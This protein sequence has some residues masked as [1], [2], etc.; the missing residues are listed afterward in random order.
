MIWELTEGWPYVFSVA[1][2]LF[3]V[4]VSAHAVL[5]KREVRSAVTWLGAIW[6]L[7]VVGAAM[8]LAFGINRIPRRVAR[9][10]SQQKRRRVLAAGLEAAMA[11]PFEESAHPSPELSSLSQLAR[12]APTFPAVGGNAVEL[13]D[14]GD[15]CYRAMI[16]AIEGAERSVALSTY[17][18]DNDRAGAMVA[19]ALVA[20]VDRGVEVRVLIDGIGAHY[21]RPTMLRGLRQRRVPVAAF[22]PSVPWRMRYMNLRNHR[23]ILVVDGTIGFTGGMNIRAG[24]L[25]DAPPAQRI[26]DTHF[27]IR[28]PL[29]GQLMQVFSEDWFFATREEL[30][31]PTWFPSPERAGDVVAMTVPD[32]PDEDFERLTWKIMAAVGWA[33]KRVRIVS[34]YFLPEQKVLAQ[35][36]IAAMRGVEVEIVIPARGNLRLVQWAATAQLGQLLEVGCRVFLSPPPFDHSKFAVIDGLY[37]TFGSANWDARSLRLNFEV[38]VE[39]YDPGVAAQLDAHFEAKAAQGREIDLDDVEGRSML[40]KLRDASARLLLPYL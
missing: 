38:N 6:I 22:L 16:E 33:R 26:Q 29:V 4:A 36:Q 2:A 8:Y 5:S 20:A 21:T 1:S 17:I 13:L 40:R 18:F 23:K 30:S 32:G 39:C 15:A 10:P 31:G 34:P 37:A 24:C 19:D 27:R 3:A 14:G 12:V 7:P 11:R 25:S 35:V 9:D 28:G